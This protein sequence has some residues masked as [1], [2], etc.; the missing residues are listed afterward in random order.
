[1]AALADRI[2]P[3]WPIVRNVVTPVLRA[4]SNGFRSIAYLNLVRFR[5]QTEHVPAALLD[6]SWP[7]FREQV[8]AL[9][10]GFIV[11][12]GKLTYNQFLRGERLFGSFGVPHT[13]IQRMKGDVSLPPEARDDL[14]RIAA[15]WRGVAPGRP[16]AS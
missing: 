4:T 12:L 14:I 8:E 16:N 13:K 1:M 6:R 15:E 7:G 10:P 9:R 2:M 5:T 11:V 3:S